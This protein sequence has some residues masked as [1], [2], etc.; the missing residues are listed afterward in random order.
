MERRPDAFGFN[1]DPHDVSVAFS[2][3]LAVSSS[4]GAD[5]RAEYM[6]PCV[7]ERPQP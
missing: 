7:H 2:H 4:S 3:L 5:P 6:Y 1:R